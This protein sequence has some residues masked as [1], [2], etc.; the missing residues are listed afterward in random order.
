MY[1][2]ILWKNSQRKCKD[3]QG[4]FIAGPNPQ[5]MNLTKEEITRLTTTVSCAG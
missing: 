5:T 2:Y 3:D 4:M 1:I